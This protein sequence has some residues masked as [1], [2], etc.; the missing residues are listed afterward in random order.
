MP[1]LGCSPML[2]RLPFFE[3]L[4]K[5]NAYNP[6]ISLHDHDLSVS[7]AAGKA[8]DTTTTYHIYPALT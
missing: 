2:V 1:L 6:D 7:L 3:S 5:H 4:F 8:A